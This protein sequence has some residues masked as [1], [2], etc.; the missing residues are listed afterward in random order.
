MLKKLLSTGF[1]FL[2][3]F[4]L[5]G[6]AQAKDISGTLLTGDF[7]GVKDDIKSVLHYDGSALV[8]YPDEDDTGVVV[9]GKL[10]ASDGGD[11]LNATTMTNDEVSGAE[12]YVIRDL[13]IEAYKGNPSEHV[14]NYVAWIAEYYDSDGVFI[15]EI[16]HL[17]QIDSGFYLDDM[18]LNPH[19]L[20]LERFDAPVTNDPIMINDLLTV[21]NQG[22]IDFEIGDA[23]ESSISIKLINQEQVIL[24]REIPQD[25]WEEY[26]P[27]PITNLTEDMVN[28]GDNLFYFVDQ[29][30]DEFELFNWA[31][32][33]SSTAESIATIEG[34][35]LGSYKVGNNIYAVYHRDNDAYLATLENDHGVWSTSE[36]R[37]FSNIGDI[38]KGEVHFNDYGS[39]Q[40]I[41]VFKAV[42]NS[43]KHLHVAV[44]KS[45]GWVKEQNIF[46]KP[47]SL[48]LPK[49]QAFENGQ[50]NLL[51]KWGSK[52]YSSTYNA[53]D[54]SWST[55]VKKSRTY[56]G[57]IWKFLY[58]KDPEYYNNKTIEWFTSPSKKY[59]V[60]RN[61]DIADALSGSALSRLK[62]N[63][64]MVAHESLNDYHLFVFRNG[65]KLRAAAQEQANIF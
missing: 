35:Y 41:V 27:K 33:Y 4:L 46:A 40:V 15:T 62:K 55:P 20:H 8:A 34:E 25:D 6:P 26:E 63:F 61:W 44:Q 10:T 39:G 60:L 50:V 31:D 47:S 29:Q 49:I 45:S 38:R 37:V 14:D 9:Y 21:E 19:A 18:T 3:I 64:N 56:A 51:W 48:Y 11:W 65:D 12:S 32:G 17:Y 24:G 36:Q 58:S 53:G 1:L 23:G 28:I 42:K 57:R 59:Y 54:T 5:M 43:K 22:D 7:P 13:Q 52:L 16:A 2:G 30:E